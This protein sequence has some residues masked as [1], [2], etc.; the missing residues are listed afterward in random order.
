MWPQAKDCRSHQKLE[1]AGR[2]LPFRFQKVHSPVATLVL[3]FWP[4]G[5]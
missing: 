5:L 4:P 3:D 2:I 1:E